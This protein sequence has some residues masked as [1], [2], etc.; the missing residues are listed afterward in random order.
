MLVRLF[1]KECER[2]DHVD[3]LWVEATAAEAGSAIFPRLSSEQII[4][5]RKVAG[6]TGHLARMTGKPDLT[7]C[8][9]VAND[10]SSIHP[11][12]VHYPFH[13]LW[14]AY[15][16]FRDMPERT[17]R[18]LDELRDIALPTVSEDEDE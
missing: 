4:Q 16:P 1:W 11:H 3:A 14:N 10:L 17:I 18:S 8:F 7:F 15:S 12:E 6:R 5:S 9:L 13:Q 2:C